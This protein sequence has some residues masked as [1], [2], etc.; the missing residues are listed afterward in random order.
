M[1]NEQTVEQMK[2]RGAALR[3]STL[4]LVSSLK[5]ENVKR[6]IQRTVLFNLDDLDTVVLG[7]FERD[8]S[9]R[10]AQM[11]LRLGETLLQLADA[12]LSVWRQRVE[13]HGPGFDL[14]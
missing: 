5:S 12:N 7:A 6:H 4:A 14:V 8:L 11:W 13:Q 1:A 10:D 9:P 3:A 2:A